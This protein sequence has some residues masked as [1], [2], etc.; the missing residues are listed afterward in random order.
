MSEQYADILARNSQGLSM[1]GSE[2]NSTDTSFPI[3]TGPA[4]FA[5]SSSLPPLPD[6]VLASGGP[7]F[8]LPTRSFLETTSFLPSSQMNN[9]VQISIRALPNLPHAE[10]HGVPNASS[11][12]SSFS[13]SP[14]PE[15]LTIS[16]LNLSDDLV[17]MDV[18]QGVM[19][20]DPVACASSLGGP[21]GGMLANNI[22]LPSE[23]ISNSLS[24]D[25]ASREWGLSPR[26]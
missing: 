14:Y 5:G 21:L 25:I 4:P 7:V 3:S 9:E 17:S 24:S 20:W 19:N 18:G 22:N 13:S 6:P 8:N 10:Y 2:L 1:Q 16:P 26:Y 15:N 11:E 12:L 23:A